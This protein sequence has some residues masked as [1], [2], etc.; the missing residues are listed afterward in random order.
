MYAETLIVRS[1]VKT[2]ESNRKVRYSKLTHNESRSEVN[3]VTY[4]PGV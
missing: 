2:A 3:G 1:S 4:M